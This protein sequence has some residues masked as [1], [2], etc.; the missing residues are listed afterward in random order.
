M[1]RTQ[2]MVQLTSDLLDDLDLEATARGIS[3]SALIREVLEAHLA[4]R[5]ADVVGEQIAEG[6]RR[7]PPATPD[8]WGSMESFADVAAREVMQRLSA[9]EREAGFEPG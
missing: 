1:A 4:E 9:E 3:R 5:R 8:E 2:T 6:Y 7:I